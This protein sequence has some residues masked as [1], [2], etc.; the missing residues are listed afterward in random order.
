MSSFAPLQIAATCAAVLW[1]LG[2]GLALVL[3]TRARAAERS[4]RLA[5]LQAGL[6][7]LYRAIEAEP[8]P[9][10]LELVVDALEEQAEM[11]AQAKAAPGK[12]APTG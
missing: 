11:A 3:W 2:A 12:V 10:R 9:G 8:A 7:G 6:T 5:A 4:R 1:P